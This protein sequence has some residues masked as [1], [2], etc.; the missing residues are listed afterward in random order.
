MRSPPSSVRGSRQRHLAEGKGAGKK[1]VCD[2]RALHA[3]EHVG[4]FVLMAFELL[5]WSRGVAG[6]GGRASGAARCPHAARFVWPP[7]FKHRGAQR[8][9]L[10]TAP[11]GRFPQESRCARGFSWSLNS[12]LCGGTWPCT[13]AAVGAQADGEGAERSSSRGCLW[14]VG[15]SARCSQAAFLARAIRRGS[16]SWALAVS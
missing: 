8:R 16:R 1:G 2:S 11:L 5:R 14:M 10:L 3:G 12:V 13:C 9:P 7:P 15:C 6:F 4:A